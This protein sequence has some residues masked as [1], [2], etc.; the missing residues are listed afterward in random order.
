MLSK[1]QRRRLEEEKNSLEQLYTLQSQ[2]VAKIRIAL[3]IEND[4]SRKFQ[5]EKQ[6][7]QEEN[8]LQ[9]KSARLDEIEKQLQSAQPLEQTQHNPIGEKQSRSQNAMGMNRARKL[10]IEILQQ[11]I[12]KLEKDY[13]AVADKKRRESNPQEQNNLQLQLDD[14]NKLMEE[15]EQQLQELGYGDE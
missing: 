9:S 2:K 4:P 13:K 12:E 15:K 6:I 8:E 1:D 7:E 3:V 14:I 5:Y 11:D 10:Q